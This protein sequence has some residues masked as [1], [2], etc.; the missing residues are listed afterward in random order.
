MRISLENI[1]EH[2]DW[3]M[4]ALIAANIVF[5]SVLTF[6]PGIHNKITSG[7]INFIKKI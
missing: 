6:F 1:I 5:F 2:F 7:I 3:V 4:G